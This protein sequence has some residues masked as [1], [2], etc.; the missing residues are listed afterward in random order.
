MRIALA[1]LFACLIASSNAFAHK[2]RILAIAQDGTLADIPSEFG[3]AN[4]KV[5]FSAPMSDSPPITSMVLNLGEK[6]IELP[7]CITGF[8]RSRSMD[9]VRAMGSWYHNE[10]RLPYYLSLTFFDPG[11]S[12]KEWANPGFTLLFNLRTGKVIKMEVQIVR[13]Q[14]RSIQHLPVD[15]TSRCTPAVLATIVDTSAQ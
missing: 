11:Y 1:L 8:L 10:A 4:L 2:D 15:F 3:P 6:R 5:N 13:E 14:G 12:I 7:V 9:E